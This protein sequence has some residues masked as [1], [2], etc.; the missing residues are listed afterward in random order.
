MK[1]RNYY[2]IAAGLIAVAYTIATP[3]FQAPDEVGHYW[4]SCSI[5]RGTI[6]P[7]MTDGQ[8]SALVPLG[9]REIVRTLWQPT[10]G[11]PDVKIG[12]ARLRAAAMVPLDRITLG[13]VRFPAYYT[14]VPNAPA[15]LGCWLGDVMSMRPFYSF[16]LGR[17]LNAA[18]LVLLMWL[19]A[20]RLDRCSNSI[21]AIGLL[22]MTL[23]LAG[24]YSADAVTIGV[25]SF[26]TALVLT[27]SEKRGY[28]VSLVISAFVLALCKPVY[29]L[30]P[31]L[32]IIKSERPWKTYVPRYVALVG[33]VALGVTLSAMTAQ[34]YYFPMRRDVATSPVAQLAH[35]RGDPVQ[36]ARIALRDYGTNAH[37]YADHLIGH[38]GWLDIQLPKHLVDLAI[39]LLLA[40]G[41]TTPMTITPAQR[42]A[43]GLIVALSCGLISLSQ[44]LV[45][46]PIGA[47][48]ID[49]MQGRYFLPLAPMGLSV[50]GVS[51]TTDRVRAI[52][53]A[54]FAC[55]VFILDAIGI[56][57]VINRYY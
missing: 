1:L 17:M 37:Q 19:A 15:I 40:V 41:V 52:V 47:D 51:G 39:L 35:V 10:A 56:F 34:R 57:L 26:V 5:A 55:A 25:S 2:V 32:A 38:L 9:V 12:V 43:G 20:T 33:A 11:R 16:Y 8:P 53:F 23:Y 4:R 21:I 7:T 48:F 31:L 28:W 27:P 45:W 50:I 30:L 14:P 29:F 36:F 22:P 42:L 24:S 44:Y 54:F 13:R 49:G 46:T 3:P 18:T 6:L